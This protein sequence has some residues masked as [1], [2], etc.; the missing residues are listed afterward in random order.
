MA[1][2]GLGGAARGEGPGGVIEPFAANGEALG[3]GEGARR[4]ALYWTTSSVATAAKAVEDVQD[5]V[6]IPLALEALG[7]DTFGRPNSSG[8]T[9]TG[10]EDFRG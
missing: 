1:D 6:D 9:A 5:F 4:S 3:L 2:G 10:R 7:E 8:G